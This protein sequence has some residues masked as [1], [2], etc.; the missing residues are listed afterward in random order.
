MAKTMRKRLISFIPFKHVIISTNLTLDEIVGLF[1]NSIS[2]RL[3]I[4]QSLSRNMKDIQGNVSQQGFSIR[5]TNYHLR[6]PG[7]IYLIG[8]FIPHSDGI[9]IEAY[10][11]GSLYL[12]LFL[13]IGAG[14]FL[15]LQAISEEDSIALF[16][17]L[18]A[19]FS[20]FIGFFV[21]V[22][23]L[24]WFIGTLLEKYII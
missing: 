8:K 19:I 20:G 12:T 4:Y 24:D 17:S 9:K 5:L 21:E 3:Y 13:F 2:P 6:S 1:S 16:A 22:D 7:Y 11:T 15:F 18:V 23:R 10:I 14:F